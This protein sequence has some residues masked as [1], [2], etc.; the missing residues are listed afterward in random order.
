LIYQWKKGG[1]NI[2]GATGT[3]LTLNAVTVAD[4]GNYTVTVSNVVR[5][6]TSST[7]TL[8]V[9]VPPPVAPTNV[10]PTG[11]IATLTPEFIFAAVANATDYRVITWDVSNVYTTNAWVSALDAGVPTGT[12]L[13]SISL[14]PLSV[15]YHAWAVQAQNQ[16]GV[17]PH[18]VFTGFSINPLPGAPT[19]VA[20]AGT[21]YTPT[22]EFTFNA[23]ANVAQYRI[24]LWNAAN[25]YTTNAWVNAAD[26]GVPSG[27]GVGSIA[28]GTLPAGYHAW[29]VQS[30]NP[31]GLSSR[32]IFTG[33][34][35]NLIPG[36]PTSLAPA[37]TIATFSPAFTFNAVANATQY[38]IILW[39]AVSGYSTN[40]WVNAATAGVPTGSGTGTIALGSMA[41]G[42]HAWAIQAQSPYGLSDRSAFIGFTINPQA[43][44]PTPVGPSG[45]VATLTPTFTFGASSNATDYRIIL[46]DATNGYS[47]NAW[48]SAA[49]AG[50]PAGT[51]TGSITIGPLTAGYHAWAV[52]SQNAYGLSSRSVFT[53]VT[54]H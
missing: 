17:S 47:T 46:W 30:Q 52:Q 54:L 31:Y 39:D 53:G 45:S 20:P 3:T 15:G 14:A 41:P 8:T 13:G 19:P 38:R 48:V 1:V 42:Y 22:P 23:A 43:V 11:T 33:F 7:A 35:V 6:I 28:L 9:I 24:I 49:A 25:G 16:G 32:S 27:T 51:G 2:P 21:I 18:S 44:T 34:Y 29:A 40:A 5:V 10:S 50:V 12:G 36:T 4:A 37:G 26:A